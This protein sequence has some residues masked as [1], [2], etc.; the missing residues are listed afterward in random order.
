MAAAVVMAAQ[1]AMSAGGDSLRMTP[2]VKAVQKTAPAV[3]NITVTRIV[4]RGISPFGQMFGGD[5]FDSFFDGFPARKQKFRSVSTGSGVIING[6]RG[7][8]LTNAHVLSGGSDIKVRTIDGDEFPA[9]IV[10]SDA[11]FDLA[12]LKIR[13]ARNL[14]QV[15]MG[16]SSGIFIGETVIAI[17]NPFGYTHTVTTGVVSALKRTVKSKQGSFTDF[18]QTDAAI[19][20]GNSGGPLL[21]ILGELIGINTAIQAQAE[22]IGF[23][24]PI[25]RAKRVVEELL[26]SG[27][28]SPV[29]I[30]VSGQDLDQSS[31]SYFGLSRVH[32]LLVTEVY[33]STPASRAQ[34]GPGDVIL[35][36]NGIEVEDKDSYLAL[37]RGQTRSEDVV[38]EVLHAEK[39]RKI[40][41][42]PQSLTNGQV[43]SFAWSRWGM[44]VDR[45]SR[46][47]GMLV[48][49][50]NKNSPA[51]RLGLQSGDKIHQIGNRRVGSQQDFI[52][53]FL[54]YRMN[55]KVMLKVQRGRN[56]YYVKLNS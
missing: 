42:R 10:G 5:H 30:G 54:R 4:E 38:L 44:A 49:K 18:I 50:V 11:D 48:T 23:A 56:F 19:N 53:A 27:K 40:R 45:D 8:V 25:N 46:G 17:G 12:V 26:A 22:G 33:K 52:D 43:Q 37:M 20:P 39:V 36:V 7:L 32:G 31:A 16:D 13:D 3:V 29:W 24:I 21:N 9:E 55:N 28:V 6:R 14:P 15:S 35:S 47:R 1:P 41:L 2:V 51:G 34:L